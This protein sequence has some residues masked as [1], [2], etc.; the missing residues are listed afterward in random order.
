MIDDGGDLVNLI[1]TKYRELLPNVIGGCEET[2]TGIIRL[3]AM[4]RE[5]ILEFPMVLVNDADCKHLFDNRYGTGQS[6]WD[7]INRTTNLIVAGKKVVVLDS[8]GDAGNIITAAPG[9]YK[10]NA[11]VIGRRA[12]AGVAP[13]EGISAIQVAAE[14]VANMKLLRIDQETTANIGVI[15]ANYATNIVPERARIIAEAMK[16]IPEDSLIL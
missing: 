10:L 6:V 1:H 3:Q 8:S 11:T 15:S 9:Q 4:A 7:G 16:K 13:E 14:A 12:H 2:T 5:G